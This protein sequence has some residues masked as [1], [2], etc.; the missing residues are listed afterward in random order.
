MGSQQKRSLKTVV[1]EDT[2]AVWTE[3]LRRLVPSSRT[4]RLAPLIAGMLHYATDIAYEKYGGKPEEGTVEHALLSASEMYDYDE[5]YSDLIV[6][7]AGLFEDAGVEYERVNSRGERYSLAERTFYEFIH[8]Y[9]MP[10]E[11]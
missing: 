2:Y 9:D 6:I 10:W 3:M 1:G 11:G 8:W 5:V 7:V 4:H